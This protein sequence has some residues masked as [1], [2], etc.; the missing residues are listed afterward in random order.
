MIDRTSF[1]TT[2]YCTDGFIP[3]KFITIIILIIIIII[4]IIIVIIIII[5]IIIIITQPTINDY[6]SQDTLERHSDIF[7]L[8]PCERNLFC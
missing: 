2:T 1:D 8:F 5:I 7:R 4:I 3:Y 6:I